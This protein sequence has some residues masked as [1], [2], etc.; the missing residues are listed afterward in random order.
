M[1][2]IK[3]KI[4][5]QRTAKPLDQCHRTG[6]RSLARKSSL[7]HQL[8]SDRPISDSKHFAHQFWATGEQKS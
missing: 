7:L 6:L 4:E 3:V 1:C 8:A 2:A 5:A